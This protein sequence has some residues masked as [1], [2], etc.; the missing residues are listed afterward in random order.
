M[1]E[2]NYSG[3]V[4]AAL[5]RCLEE[6]PETLLYGED[7]AKPGGVHGV[8]RRLWKDFGE[9]VFDTPISESAILGSAIG[10]AMMGRRPIVEIM[11]ADFFLVAFDQMVNQAANVRYISEGRLTAPLVVRTQQGH[12]P[13]ACAQ[14]SQNLEAL[15]THTPGLRVAMPSTPQDAFDVMVS[16]VHSDDPV[17]V[18]DNRTLYFG[19]KQEVVTDAAPAPIGGSHVRRTGSA[20]T[21]VAWGAITHQVLAAVDRL[22]QEGVQ[23]TVLETP[24]L[25]PF[26]HDALHRTLAGTGGRLAVVHEANTTGG[27]GGEVIVQALEA[28]V[29]SG[30]PLRIGADDS[31]IPATPEL[32]AAVIPGADLIYNELKQFAA[33]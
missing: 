31:R 14:H 5:R 21:V 9:R 16:A 32:A 3:A 25:N 23:V 11:W 15:F 20:A 24:W 8:T 2:L 17:V 10:A 18:I 22:A 26:D 12:S 27:F 6:I 19:D 1:P 7:V 13:G 28:G 4:N 30:R 29:L 33:R